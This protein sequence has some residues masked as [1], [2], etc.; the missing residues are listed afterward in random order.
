M[1]CLPPLVPL[2]ITLNLCS[3]YCLVAIGNSYSAPS[4]MLNSFSKSLFDLLHFAENVPS[5]PSL[6]TF[7]K[8][9]NHFSSSSTS[10]IH[11]FCNSLTSF[12]KIST[13]KWI[14][15]S[16]RDLTKVLQRFADFLVLVLVKVRIIVLFYSLYKT[17]TLTILWS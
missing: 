17:C 16:S 6:Y 5:S 15:Y 8:F 3:S 11:T 1:I 13:H 12:L 7:P 2:Q 4:I 14:Q 9:H 10:F